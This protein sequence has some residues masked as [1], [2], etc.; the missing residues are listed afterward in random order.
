ML[1]KF[2]IETQNKNYFQTTGRARL[3]RTWL[4]RSSAQFEVS[5]KS[6]PDSYHYRPQRS[7]A[8]VMFLHVCVILST[9]GFCSW[10]LGG[11]LIQGVSAPGGGCLLLLEVCSRGGGCLLP[12]GSAPGGLLFYFI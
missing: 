2:L 5:V 4:I 11:C 1:K 10:S 9:G 6:L 12:G 3:I 8:K 7:C